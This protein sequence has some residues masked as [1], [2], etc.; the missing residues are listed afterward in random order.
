M[1][2]SNQAMV[3]MKMGCIWVVLPGSLDIDTSATVEREIERSLAQ[4][5]QNIR[6]VFD[7]SLTRELYSTGMGFLI[8]IQKR[9]SASN[10]SMY[11]VNVSPKIRNILQAVHLDKVFPVYATDVEFEI[12]QEQFRE[13][14]NTP[15]VG[16]VFIRC[17]E[18]GMY[19]IHCSG[20][21]TATRDLA[22]LSQFRRDEAVARYLFDFNGLD[23]IDSVG[24]AT[25]IKLLRD[26]R[27]H[28]GLSFAFGANRGVT[29]LIE[30]LGMD[31]YLALL[32]DERSALGAAR[33]K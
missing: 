32:P 14:A 19:R 9:F 15:E 13:Q 21:M 28:G 20:S 1:A 17:I 25:L 33:K 23:M 16:F 11:L 7:L 26:I 2:E 29:E 31:E 10:G 3:Q 22:A 4:A 6:V 12:S 30:L 5:K 18:N 8:R 24:A 27:E